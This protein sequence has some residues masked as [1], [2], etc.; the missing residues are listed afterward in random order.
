MNARAEKMFARQTAVP[1]TQIKTGVGVIVRGTDGRILLEKR[2]D[3][4]MWGLLGGR[5]EPGE[6]VTQAAVR[7]VLEESGFQIEVTHLVGVYSHPTG[8]ILVYPDNGDIR[9]LIDIVVE[10]RIVGGSLRLSH[11]S[12]CID[13][14]APDRLPE[15]A[16][17]IPPARQPLADAVAGRQGVLS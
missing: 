9:Q 14:F 4:G 1:G 5:I 7:E 10:A 13:F 16:E 8:R 6:S 17:T 12:E 3:C 15:L 2:S 11:E